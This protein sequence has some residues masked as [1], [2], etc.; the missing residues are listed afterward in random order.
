MSHRLRQLRHRLKIY[1]TSSW[2]SKKYLLYDDIAVQNI[3]QVLIQVNGGFKQESR[4][5]TTWA[6]ARLGRATLLLLLLISIF[7]PSVLSPSNVGAESARS[8]LSS[9]NS[10]DLFLFPLPW[11]FWFN[12]WSSHSI[13]TLH[14]SSIQFIN[15]TCTSPGTHMKSTR[16]RTIMTEV[17]IIICF[18]TKKLPVNEGEGQQKLIIDYPG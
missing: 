5:W 6:S 13:Y 17:T 15:L 9:C 11:S 12:F 2:L 3:Y 16:L 4:G 8:L 18:E 7:F 10:S 14:D 1:C